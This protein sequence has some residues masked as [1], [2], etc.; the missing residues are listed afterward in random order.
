MDLK[1]HEAYLFS[2]LIVVLLIMGIYSQIFLD[3]FH[4]PVSNI[5]EH[6]KQ[7]F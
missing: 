5:I 2:Y 3:S 1:R 4:A 7:Q 6:T